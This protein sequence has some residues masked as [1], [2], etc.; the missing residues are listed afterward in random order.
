MTRSR[1]ANRRPRR[2][3]GHI[4][5]DP[6]RRRWQARP[7]VAGALRAY[8]LPLVAHVGAILVLIALAA[9]HLNL[10]VHSWV[11]DEGLYAIQVQELRQGHWDYDYAG[12]DFDRERRWFG[13]A[14]AEYH[15][16][17]L[18]P[19][20]K[21]P[22]YVL[23][24]LGAASIFGGGL[25]LYLLPMAGLV[26][27]AIAAWLLAGQF[28]QRARRPAFWLVVVSP[29]VVNAVILWAH[30]LSAA[31]T[32]F[33]AVLGV[34]ILRG[35]RLVPRL[36][37]LGV[38]LAA[39]I[40]IRTEAVLFAIAVTLSLAGAL[41]V[42]RRVA[43][44]CAL[45]AS[46]AVATVLA[47]AGER[48]LVATVTGSG[49]I[50]TSAVLASDVTALSVGFAG[51][52][53]LVVVVGLVRRLG[54]PRRLVSGLAVGA[55]ATAVTAVAVGHRVIVASP[56]FRGVRAGSL[57]AF[58]LDRWDAVR[59][60]MLDGAGTRDSNAGKGGVVVA[61]ALVILAVAGLALRAGKS[62]E[63]RLVAPAAFSTGVVIAVVLY[64]SRFMMAPHD[65]LSGY[66]AAWPVVVGGLVAVPWRRTGWV[67]RS[68]VAIVLL[69]AGAVFATQYSAGGTVE[70]GGRFLA[71]T[72]VPVAAVIT[73]GLVRRLDD[74]AWRQRLVLSAA[75][76]L[77]AAVPAVGGILMMGG[78]R[79][80]NASLY[81]HLAAPGHE[82]IV[83]VDDH[84]WRRALNAWPQHDR[85]EW[86]YATPG[87]D[88]GELLARLSRRGTEQVTLLSYSQVR[89]VGT[90]TTV[91]P[92]Q[93]ESR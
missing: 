16:R 65:E 6:A 47:V 7:V 5:L 10:L 48:A 11:T 84:A 41:I 88:L 66:L 3:S 35:H 92:S 78:A 44:A 85:H 54:L 21:H 56:W 4:R 25:G 27:A 39:G 61:G 40:L 14:Q 2:A 72:I 83:V 17:R 89:H 62:R 42:H 50:G 53:V 37:L 1:R 82:V 60:I 86:Y 93:R 24:L 64:V 49:A 67:D 19:Y 52:L 71:P 55:A 13:L 91:A 45:V 33:A 74:R 38:C 28:E 34:G 29:L 43:A 9:P 30:T 81:R 23:A 36:A 20:V 22:A 51:V 70:W 26:L 76:V 31:L 69:Y 18:Y 32:G 90:S 12:E 80:E 58:V 68:V 8:R 46:N 75:L 15:S 77:M 87:R 63:A 57:N 59:R 79:G 73:V